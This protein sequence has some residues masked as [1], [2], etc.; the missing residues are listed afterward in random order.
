MDNS[1][2]GKDGRED[3][4]ARLR[5]RPLTWLAVVVA[6]GLIVVAL[7]PGPTDDEPPGDT[8]ARDSSTAVAK[9][10]P[11][12]TLPPELRAGDAARELVAE[13]RREGR[14]YDLDAVAARADAYEQEAR[15]ADA[16]LL[17]FFA[18]R[19]GHA[20]SALALGERVDP[21]RFDQ[22]SRYLDRPDAVQALKWY[23]RAA[24]LG[25]DEGARRLEELR[26]WV[27]ARAAEGDE[28]A[29][30]LALGWR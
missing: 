12:T 23:Q 25:H 14:P 10:D 26:G 13:L 30:R 22:T 2:G 4:A 7:L 9:I 28:E 24:E 5:R 6:L 15:L 19:E 21:S 8:S 20:P 1:A 3:R 16:Y 17:L 18:A 29:Q 27:E 11:R